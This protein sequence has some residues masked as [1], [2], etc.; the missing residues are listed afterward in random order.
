MKDLRTRALA[1]RYSVVEKIKRNAQDEAE[2]YLPSEI[3]NKTRFSR[4]AVS[5]EAY[6]EWNKKEDFKPR[7]IE[8]TEVQKERI[9][10]KLKMSFV[11][12]ALDARELEIVVSAMEEK[13][14]KLGEAVITQ[15]DEGDNLYVVD[16]GTLKCSRVFVRLL[17][18]MTFL[19]QVKGQ[20]AKFLKNYQPG[21]AFGELALLYNA[22]RAAT[23][24]ANEDCILWSLDRPTFTNI[25]KDAA[26]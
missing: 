25:V 15:G 12:N 26:M 9:R 24:A 10:E 21:E 20:A 14:F 13:K 18:V 5:A 17:I 7:I 6:G 2:E 4:K 8:K 11:F 3:P 16:T 1:K 22:P 19:Q 23:I